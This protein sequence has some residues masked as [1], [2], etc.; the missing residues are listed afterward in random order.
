[1]S[2][3]VQASPL[4]RLAANLEELGLEGMA[5]SVPEYVRLVA[6]GRKG[7]VDA[8]LE[9]TDA[10]I[11]LKRRADD[12]RRTRMANF[13]YIKTLAD[14]DWGFQPSVPRGLVEQLA[15]LEFIDRGDNVVLVGSP[16]VGKTH[17]SIAIGHEAV[18]ARKQVYFADCSRLVED[19]KHASAKEALARR[20]RFYEHCS[21]LIIDELG[22]LDIGKEGADL[23][24]QLVNRRYALKRSTIVT[25]N[26][27]VGRWGD[28]FGSN[29]TAS[30]VADRLCHHC[31]MIKITGRSYRLKDVSIGGEDGREEKDAL[32]AE[33][34]ASALANLAHP[35]WRD[36]RKCVGENGEKYIDANTTPPS[37]PALRGCSSRSSRWAD[38]RT[39]S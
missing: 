24:F 34:G 15:T 6:D 33:S 37:A 11:A 29:V 18:M 1:M 23:L 13:P 10:Q 3:A 25:T 9:L 26:V 20:M 27:P 7:L 22:Y 5:S 16:G 30:A 39:A 36:W 12:D 31:A 28:V 17:L 19:L 2:A 32:G 38:L 4:N 14:F 35:R 21:L 8:M